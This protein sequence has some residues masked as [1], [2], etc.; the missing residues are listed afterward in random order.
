MALSSHPQGVTTVRRLPEGA[1]K[2][3]YNMRSVRAPIATLM[4]GVSL[5]LMAGTASATDISGTISSTLT[6]TEDSQLVGNVTCTVTGAACISF[7]SS[8][9]TLRLNGFS[10]TG[11]ADPSTA[12]SGGQTAGEHGILVNGLRSV[13]IQG[14]GIVQRFRAQGIILTGA[15]SRVLVTQVTVSTNC[16]SGIFVTMASSDN[17]LEANISV[18]NGNATAACGGI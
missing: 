6:I 1:K 5:V 2:G 8:G 9:V 11:Q 12:C 17:E 7:G 15:S 10:M 13:V 18:R 16:M 3:R 14:P 4:F